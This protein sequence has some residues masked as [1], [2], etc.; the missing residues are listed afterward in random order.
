M[1][2]GQRLFRGEND[3]QTIA[4]VKATLVSPPSHHNAEVSREL[5][6]ICLRA[7]EREPT[8]RFPDCTAFAN[9]LEEVVA[10]VGWSPAENAVLMEHT[11]QARAHGAPGLALALDR[12][13]R[14]TARVHPP[15]AT[16]TRWRWRASMLA[17]TLV[18]LGVAAVA[19]FRPPAKSPPVAPVSTP[20]STSAP[21]N[22]PT[23]MDSLPTPVAPR[24]TPPAPSPLATLDSRAVKVKAPGPRV[25]HGKAVR[26]PRPRAPTPASPTAPNTPAPTTTGKVRTGQVLDPFAR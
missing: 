2:T 14:G 15:A 21:P 17:A 16:S 12:T 6:A 24:V 18:I 9:A 11:E 1:L 8:R 7:L 25:A 10:S 19:Y 23:S 20:A 3:M 26:A 22:A 5:D 13:E 4:R